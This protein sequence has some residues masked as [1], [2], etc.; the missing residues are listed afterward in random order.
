MKKVF[1]STAIDYVNGAP[2]LG[3]ALEKIQADVIARY[4]RSLGDEVFFLSGSDEN[5]L[6]NVQSAEKEGIAI[7]DLV[8]KNYEK[9]YNLKKILNLSYDDFIRTTEERHVVGAQKLWTLCKEDIYKKKYKGLYCVGCEEFYKEEELEDGLC[10][11]HKKPLELIEEENYFFKLEKYADK[12]KELIERDDIKIIP[13]KRKNEIMSFINSGLQDFCISRSSERAKG[14]G[15]NVPS[16]NTQKMWVWFDALTSY[17]SALGFGGKDELFQKFWEKGDTRLHVIGKGI[18]RFHAIY[19]PAMLLSAKIT[20][21]KIL[22]VHG[23]ITV[24]GQKMSKSIGNVIDPHELVSKYSA[25]GVRYFL[26]RE[27]PALDDGDFTYE[28]YEKRYNSD[29]ASGLGNLFSRVIAMVDKYGEIE[30]KPNEYTKKEIENV[31]NKYKDKFIYFNETLIEVWS[32]IGSCDK[33]IDQEKPWEVEDK[34]EILSNLLYSLK[35]ISQMIEPFMPET[36]IKMKEQLNE[37]DGI[38]RVKKGESLFPK[39]L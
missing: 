27:M 14:W 18:N 29:L 5:S 3:H 34:K 31:W 25:D 33:Y 37:E 20:L 17:I 19:W 23:Y 15:I 2:H 16:D 22:F 10:P 39:I 8:D 21:P 32:L 28:K 24:D 26:L 7:K 9:F 6:K 4:H 13:E 35:N 38:F 1:I 36:A 30:I 11:E 12:I